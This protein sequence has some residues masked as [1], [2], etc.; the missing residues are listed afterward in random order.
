[1][2]S[3]PV[4]GLTA[5]AL[6]APNATVSELTPAGDGHTWVATLVAGRRSRAGRPMCLPST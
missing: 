1:M 5:D 6:N 3:E 2:F 4:S